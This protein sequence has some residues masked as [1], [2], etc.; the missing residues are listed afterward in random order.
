[1]VK[2]IVECY[3]PNHTSIFLANEEAR[4]KNV[5]ICEILSDVLSTEAQPCGHYMNCIFKYCLQYS[6]F[7]FSTWKD[8]ST[9][10]G[11]EG[12]VH[13]AGVE[14]DLYHMK[15]IWTKLKYESPQNTQIGQNMNQRICKLF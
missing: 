7:V 1:M 12:A 3:D 15:Q 14:C 11:V 8:S 9:F 5:I 2:C 10:S 6:A 4:I 13:R